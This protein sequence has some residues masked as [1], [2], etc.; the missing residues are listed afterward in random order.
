MTKFKDDTHDKKKRPNLSTVGGLLKKYP[1][2]T[3]G[4]IRH[5]LF[6]MNENGLHRAVKKM[7]RRILI[8]EDEF[9]N[10][11]EEQSVRSTKGGSK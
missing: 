8:D 3:E 4:G 6:H 5:F 10:W 1:W 9:F 7:G 11:I 2:L